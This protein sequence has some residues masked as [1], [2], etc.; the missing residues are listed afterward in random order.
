[1]EEDKHGEVQN[2]LDQLLGSVLIDVQAMTCIQEGRNEHNK[3]ELAAN[4]LKSVC[5][6]NTRFNSGFGGP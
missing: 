3:A 2:R 5:C 6:S 1:M 4:L